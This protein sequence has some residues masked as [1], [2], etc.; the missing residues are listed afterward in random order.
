MLGI[1]FAIT[2]FRQSVLGR[3]VQVL[4]GHKP[5]IHV[6]YKP[7]DEVPPR[8]QR[9][10]VALMP[11]QFSL[12][13]KPGQHLVCT[14]AFSRAPLPEQNPAPEECRDI[15]EYISMVLEEAP[16]GIGDIQQTS[17][18]DFLLSSVMQRVLTNG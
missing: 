5:L 16:V 11:Y 9:W 7:F 17:K 13:Y 8:L 14:D 10:L 2:R 6:I 18:E 3:N 15:G 4:T 12:N 1:V